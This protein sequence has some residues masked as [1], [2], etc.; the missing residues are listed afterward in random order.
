MRE[1]PYENNELPNTEALA[2][3]AFEEAILNAAAYSNSLNSNTSIEFTATTLSPVIV[4]SEHESSFG[5]LED[6]EQNISK[7]SSLEITNVI[8][9][10]K[11]QSVNIFSPQET[12]T[13]PKKQD[14]SGVSA[15]KQVDLID[16][17]LVSRLKNNFKK[18]PFRVCFIFSLYGWASIIFFLLAIVE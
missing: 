2:A 8:S 14:S 13:I 15:Q 1:M 7:Y 17:I 18:I 12:E 5:V 10:N 9:E 3:E 4:S 16:Y 11:L 6:P